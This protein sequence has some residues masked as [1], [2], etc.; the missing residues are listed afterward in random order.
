MSIH[1]DPTQRFG[2]PFATN[3]LPSSGGGGGGGIPGGCLIIAIILILLALCRACS[4]GEAET[5]PEQNPAVFSTPGL[6]AEQ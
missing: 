6:H 1:D 3:R 5:G 2:D 4:S